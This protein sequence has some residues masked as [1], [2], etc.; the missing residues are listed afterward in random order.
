MAEDKKPSDYY[1]LDVIGQRNWKLG[2]IREVRYQIGLKES[3]P[4]DMSGMEQLLLIDAILRE[5]FD[6]M[7]RQAP[8]GFLSVCRRLVQ[9]TF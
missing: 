8:K 6:S 9:L 5:A 3:I 2:P 7:I 1:S 4:E